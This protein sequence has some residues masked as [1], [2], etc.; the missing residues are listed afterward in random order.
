MFVKQKVE[1]IQTAHGG[2]QIS[3]TRRC[4]KTNYV[5]D[6]L[7]ENRPIVVKAYVVP[8]LKNDLLSVKGLNQFGYRVIHDEDEEE[9]GAFAVINKKIDKAKSFPFMS[10][11]SNLFSLKLEQMC[12]TQFEKQSGYELWHQ[13]LG[14]SSNRNIQDS[15]KWNNGLEDLKGLTY[16]EHVK[17]PSCMIGKATLEDFPKARHIKVKP[18]HQINVDAFSSSIPSIQVYNHAVVFVDKCT[19]Y[20][21]I[22]G[23][24]TKDQ[25]INDVKR[26]NSDIAYL[27]TKDRLVVVVRNNA[28]ENKSQEV[29]E[30][31]QS[32][33][34]RNHFS[35]PR[36]QWQNGP[37]ESTINS[38]MQITRTVMVES[39]LG[40]RF[41]F[42][43]ATAGI[44][45]CNATF[46]A[47]IGTTPHHLMYGQKKDVSGSRAFGR[48]AWVYI[49]PQRRAKGKHMPR[50]EETIHVGFAISTSAWSFYIQE[51]KK[52]VATN[53]VKF[54]E[55]EFP[56]RKRSMVE[57]HLIDISTDMLF[58]SPSNVKWVS[59]NKFHVGNYDKVHYDNFSDVMVLRVVSDSNTYARTSMSRWQHDQLSLHKSRHQE[60]A[61]FAGVKHHTL[62]GLD[63]R[64]N[65]DK[66]PRNLRCNEGA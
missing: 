14:Y 65:P 44:D 19:G 58:Q 3:T 60:Q 35:T 51:R 62:K 57:K 12:A 31:F 50:A 45:A 66:P 26:W 43:A 10:E 48:R 28:G 25:M 64:I 20:R 4:L 49:D 24:K 23:M 53:Q 32:K 6:R 56:F 22:Y 54:S 55:H 34:I 29:K 15:I 27:R 18:L 38:I 47:R 41:W 1:E 5:R 21:W 37:A 36:Q 2:T 42:R 7:G 16:G 39:E 8:G 40:G 63:P 30:L 33:G 9:S 46:K 61:N 11:H 52:I 17:R 59:Y 13:R